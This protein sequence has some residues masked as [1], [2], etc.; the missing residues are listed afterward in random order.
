MRERLKITLAAS[1]SAGAFFTSH[2]CFSPF[3]RLRSH[4]VQLDKS[5]SC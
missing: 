4:L 2:V 3:Q 5:I 1:V